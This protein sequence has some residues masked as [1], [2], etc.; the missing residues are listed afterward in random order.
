MNQL[1]L[2]NNKQLAWNEYGVPDGEPV[3][4]FHGAI[5]SRREAKAADKIAN[6][7]G[8]RLIAPERPG[9]G[10]SDPQDNFKL[11]DWPSL[12]L[13]LANKLNINQFSIIGFSV[14]SNY[15][16]ACAHSIPERL[17]KLTLVGGLAPYQTEV[18]QKHISPDFKPLYDLSLYDEDAALQQMSEMAASPEGLFNIIHSTL[19]LCDKTLFEQDHIRTH[20][21]R[22]IYLAI[23]NSVFG[24]ANDIY[25]LTRPWQF[26]LAEINLPVNIWHG[27]N[28]KLIGYAI[29]EYLS[30]KLTN[31]SFYSQDD[32]GH[33]FLFDKWHDI[34]KSIKS[35]IV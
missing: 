4:Y 1:L 28:D 20:Y 11:L 24:C 6:N 34:L 18:M 22:S 14:G 2:S 30:T 19:S 26:D 7:L 31:S 32:S 16:L 13:Q 3:F 27:R 8:I 35:G 25:N 17:S 10:D 29:G 5:G 9:Y 15:A 33:Y 12:V 23:K 21:K